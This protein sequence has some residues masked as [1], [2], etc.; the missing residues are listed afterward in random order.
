MSESVDAIDAE[1]A[2]AVD[3]DDG[4]DRLV[5]L[6]NDAIRA[7]RR[8]LAIVLWWAFELLAGYALAYPLLAFA[9]GAYGAHPRGDAPL[10]EAGALPL[11]DLVFRARALAPALTA[12]AT[13][14]TIA[15]VV[16]GVFPLAAFLVSVAHATPDRRAPPLRRVLPRA[17]RAFLPLVALLAGMSLVELLLAGLALLAGSWMQS[18]LRTTLGEARAQQ[19]GAA[20]ALVLLVLTAAAGVLHDLARAAAV[21]FEVGAFRALRLA[22]N[23]LRRGVLR[24]LWSWGWRASVAWFPVAMGALVAGRLG[25]RGGAALVAIWVIHQ[26]VVFARVA[27]RASWLAKAVRLVDDAHRVLKPTRG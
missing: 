7:R 8:P 14:I 13:V 19:L 4:R 23:T 17:A 1:E 21:R 10:F 27:L 22:L 3:R 11:A 15:A 25:G 24:S 18:A 20:L 5:L 2:I 16:A 6:A 9:R 26:L 12:H